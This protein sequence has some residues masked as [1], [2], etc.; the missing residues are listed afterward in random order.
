MSKLWYPVALTISVASCGGETDSGSFRPSTGG[1]TQV[2]TGIPTQTGGVTTAAHYGPIQ[3]MGGTT[4]EDTAMGGT[5][6]AGGHGSI[7]TGTPD[8]TGGRSIVYIYGAIGVY[9]LR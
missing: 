6:A 3:V 8:E 5:L 9:G 4:S 7:D 1:S 2:D